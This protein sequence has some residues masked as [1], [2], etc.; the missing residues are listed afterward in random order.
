[1]VRIW[2]CL[3]AI[4]LLAGGCLGG[5]AGDTEGRSTTVGDARSSVPIVPH[6]PATHVRVTVVVH[7]RQPQAGNNVGRDLTVRLRL[8]CAPRVMYLAD[9]DELC[10]RVEADPARFADTTTV[11]GC[12]GKAPTITIAVDGRL[13]GRK[14]AFAYYG[15]CGSPSAGAWMAL[16][17]KEPAV[18]AAT[19]A[20]RA[21]PVRV[22]YVRGMGLGRAISRLQTRGLLASVPAGWPPIPGVVTHQSRAPGSR[23]LSGS[24]VRLRVTPVVTSCCMMPAPAR[25]TPQ[26]VGLPYTQAEAAMRGWLRVQGRTPALTGPLSLYGLDAF[27]VAFQW[28]PAGLPTPPEGVSVRLVRRSA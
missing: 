25:P 7:G 8:S 20:A 17:H 15:G 28:V 19:K 14:L 26:L 16:V 6:Q 3:P 18:V 21:A 22:P 27:V 12:Y 11:P 24:I 4:A 5:S 23:T 13:N 2:L 9:T 10:R 1:M